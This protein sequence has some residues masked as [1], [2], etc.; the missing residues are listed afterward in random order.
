[1]IGDGNAS[2]TPAGAQRRIFSSVGLHRNRRTGWR[3]I[4]NGIYTNLD[5]DIADDDAFRGEIATESLSRLGISRFET[6]GEVARREKVHIGRD[7]DDFFLMS[8]GL[9]G[10]AIYRQFG[11]ECVLRP[12]T[13]T[14]LYTAEPYMFAHRERISALTLKLPASA[15]RARNDDPFGL[16]AIARP[17][18]PG[19]LQT[20]RDLILSIMNGH[21]VPSG[22][23]AG[24]VEA[25]ILDLLGVVLERRED[26]S[27]SA[28]TS[29]RW[30]I[31]RRA[32]AFMQENLGRPDLTPERIAA[33]IGVST[34]YV[35]RVFEDADQ[36]LCESLMRMRLDRSRQDLA[37]HGPMSIKEIAMR[38]GFKSQSHFSSQFKARF[39]TTPRAFR[40]SPG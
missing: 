33:G 27:A 9:E 18:E 19:M 8:F 31:Q 17:V 35:H 30:A 5:I 34:R 39:G 16:C 3:D 11:R 15:L 32:L 21:D 24:V 37:D 4:I 6:D 38:N 28:G 12:D 13:Y 36:T 26:A 20:V 22:P 40:Q 25:C 14:M 7:T 1:M 29:V 23:E 10:E 2:T